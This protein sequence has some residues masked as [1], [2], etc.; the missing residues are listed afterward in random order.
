[1]RSKD[2][3]DL[4]AICNRLKTILLF[5]CVLLITDHALGVTCYAGIIERVVAYVDDSAITMSEYEERYEKM[6]NAVGSI[7]EREV[8]DSM[9]NRALILKEAKKIKLEANST[10][11]IMAEYIDIKIKALIIIKEEDINR[12]YS[13][14]LSSFGGKEYSVVRDN[15]EAYLF[16]LE[17][18]KKLKKHLEELRESA[19]IK[20]ML[21]E[22]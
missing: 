15:I 22:K 9:I 10:D 20:I 4:S 12:F 5:C 6:K 2:R 1:M 8:I 11:D 16:E 13:A 3:N 19:E 7:T 17:T 18:N 21:T 14:N